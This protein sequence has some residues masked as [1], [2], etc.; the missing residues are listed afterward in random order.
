MTRILIGLISRDGDRLGHLVRGVQMMRSFGK[1]FEVDIY[2]DVKNVELDATD[3]PALCCTLEADTDSSLDRF[4]AMVRETDWAL[5]KKGLEIAV[6]QYGDRRPVGQ[7]PREFAA[8]GEVFLP[9]AEFA[10]ICDWGQQLTD[11]DARVAGE[12]L[13]EPGG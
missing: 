10:K 12:W 8:P 6:I 11:G 7:A 1:E 9:A 5:G 4:G 3:S 2:S 13:A